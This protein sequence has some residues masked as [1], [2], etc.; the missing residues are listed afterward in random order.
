MTNT[1]SLRTSGLPEDMRL[2]LHQYPRDAWQAHP[3]FR[4]K[5]Q[6][7]LRAHQMFRHL[8]ARVRQDSEA[9]LNRDMDPDAYADRLSRYGGALVGNLH[10]HHGWEDHSYFPE[11]SAAD[12]RFDKGLELLEQDHADLDRV[13]DSFTR[14]ANRAIKLTTLDAAQ[15]RDEAGQ[16]HG[17]AET[18][19]A[20][21]DRHLGD[22][23]DLAVPIILH[24][25]LRG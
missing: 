9:V 18:I 6:G 15:A 19:E 1:H 14:S 13:L 22:E 11:L 20:F 4:E 24:H 10:G 7:W 8:A 16:V 23:E 12:P 17:L 2:L 25:R 3:G 5:T 21:L